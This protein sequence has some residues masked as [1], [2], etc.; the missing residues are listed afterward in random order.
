MFVAQKLVASSAAL[1]AVALVGCDWSQAHPKT[2]TVSQIEDEN[3]K[4]RSQ[5]DELE[6]AGTSSE[7]SDMRVGASSSTNT[8]AVSRVGGA[9]LSQIEDE[10]LQLRTQV[11]QLEEANQ[12]LLSA[13]SANSVNDDSN[14]PET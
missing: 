6:D 3:V 12:T 10:N 2:E 7:N 9:K 5:V 1:M 11:D 13:N 4:L 8:T 14:L